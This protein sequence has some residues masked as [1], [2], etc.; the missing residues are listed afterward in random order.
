MGMTTESCPE[1]LTSCHSCSSLHTFPSISKPPYL[2]MP[3]CQVH[4][5]GRAL[6]QPLHGGKKARSQSQSLSSQDS[7]ERRPCGFGLSAALPLA[8]TKSQSASMS[9]TLQV[10]K[11]LSQWEIMH[12]KIQKTEKCHTSSSWLAP[13]L[14]CGFK[15]QDR[16]KRLKV[17][18]RVQRNPI[19]GRG[20]PVPIC[21]PGHSIGPAA[22]LEKP[23]RPTGDP[24]AFSLTWE[25]SWAQKL[26]PKHHWTANLLGR[27]NCRSMIWKWALKLGSAANCC[28]WPQYW[29]SISQLINSDPIEVWHLKNN[30]NNI[31]AMSL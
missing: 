11:S 7:F 26:T 19:Y 12:A 13:F 6:K 10:S 15:E 8:T 23:D 29:E 18:S 17:S 22:Q 30:P 9:P 14:S 21:R 1:W 27:A 5:L 2:W 28:I 25:P 31:P 20:R 16:R 24:T 3:H 4:S